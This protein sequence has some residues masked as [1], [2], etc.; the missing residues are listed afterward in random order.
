MATTSS[1]D[2]GVDQGIADLP[3][4]PLRGS[5]G[6]MAA[7]RAPANWG[8]PGGALANQFWPTICCSAGHAGLTA[9]CQ[10]GRHLG[11]IALSACEAGPGYGGGAFSC[12]REV[13]GTPGGSASSCGMAAKH[14]LISESHRTT[15]NAPLGVGSAAR[16]VYVTG[17]RIVSLGVSAALL[18]TIRTATF[19]PRSAAAVTC[20]RT[21]AWGDWA[22][23]SAAKGARGYW[24]VHTMHANDWNVFPGGFAAQV[25]WVGTDGD[26]ADTTWVEVGAT[27]GWEQHDLYAFY[28]AEEFNGDPNTYL[29]LKFSRVP[30]IGQGVLFSAYQTVTNNYRAE[31]SVGGVTESLLWTGHNPNTVDWSAGLESTCQT[32]QVNNTYVFYTQ[33]LRKSDGV[34]VNPSSA[35]TPF[36]NSPAFFGW[37]ASPLTFRTRLNSTS[38][39]ACS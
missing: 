16:E 4:P 21:E 2:V 25:I 14:L 5:P 7:I 33:F 34:W 19:S 24:F 31:I 38:S 32:N 9:G 13:H 3:A 23:Q 6:T 22:P 17:K 37:C 27:R 15:L 20:V 29:E 39:D 36:A 26:Q 8:H 18:L 12:A 11:K 30:V 1:D 35:K 10:G 28:T